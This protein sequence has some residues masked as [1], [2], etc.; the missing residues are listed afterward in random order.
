MRVGSITTTVS[1]FMRGMARWAS[2]GSSAS[3]MS[4]SPREMK[5]LA[6][7]DDQGGLHAAA[8]LGE[9]VILAHAN[10]EPRRHPRGAEQ[11]DRAQDSLAPDTDGQAA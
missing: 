6:R 10:L 9:A 8:P 3:T 5:P 4:A 7:P 2:S 11:A 1:E